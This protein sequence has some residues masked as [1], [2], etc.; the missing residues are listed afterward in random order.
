MIRSMNHGVFIDEL[1]MFCSDETMDHDHHG[2]REPWVH[3]RAM[4]LFIK[5]IKREIKGDR[6]FLDFP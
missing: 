3:D 1:V 6:L 4:I 5:R 2:N